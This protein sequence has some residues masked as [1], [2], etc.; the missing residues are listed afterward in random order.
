LQFKG[1][2][3]RPSEMAIFSEIDDL[4]GV[5]NAFTSQEMT[6][7]YLKVQSSKFAAAFDLVADIF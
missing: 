3:K 4:G 6:G 5:A 2:A 1:T 7:Y